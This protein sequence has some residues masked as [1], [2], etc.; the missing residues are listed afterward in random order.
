MAGKGSS[1]NSSMI[2]QPF[3]SLLSGQQSL[4]AVQDSCVRP[5]TGDRLPLPANLCS[6]PCPAPITPAQE[7]QRL[8]PSEHPS[9]QLRFTPFHPVLSATEED[10]T[11][12]PPPPTIPLSHYN[13]H[14]L[15]II[16]IN[17]LY[18]L[19]RYKYVT[20][21][22]CL[23]WMENRQ[24]LL[25]E[26]MGSKGP[27]WAQHT[28]TQWLF[29]QRAHKIL[30]ATVKSTLHTGRDYTGPLISVGPRLSDSKVGATVSPTWSSYII[31]R[32]GTTWSC[33]YS[34]LPIS[35][36]SKIII[37]FG[38]ECFSVTK[39][40]PTRMTMIKFSFMKLTSLH[41]LCH[42]PELVWG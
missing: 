31:K 5:A 7:T 34:I 10:A 28:H 1:H 21:N 30:P 38:K 35:G 14:T 12:T 26:R 29:T 25:T 19:F 8:L 22:P 11:G 23:K 39:E 27:L 17:Y 3:P 36:L 32:E 33:Q 2:G 9:C 42:G 6:L 13:P 18:I 24:I 20:W 37:S 41:F 16:S 40:H 15:L 4:L